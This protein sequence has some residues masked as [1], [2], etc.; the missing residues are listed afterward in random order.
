MIDLNVI[1]TARSEKDEDERRG[2]GDRHSGCDDQES[3]ERSDVGAVQ[4]D[5]CIKLILRHFKDTLSCAKD[6]GKK[7]VPA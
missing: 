4:L 3:F 1:V 7:A 6:P 5:L 2:S